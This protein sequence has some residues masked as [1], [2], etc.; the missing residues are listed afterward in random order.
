MTECSREGD[1]FELRDLKMKGA[2]GQEER[3]HKSKTKCGIFNNQKYHLHHLQSVYHT[4]EEE[5]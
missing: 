3:R 2:G 5:V 1:P 4:R